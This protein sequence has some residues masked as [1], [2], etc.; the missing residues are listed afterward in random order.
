MKYTSRVN[1]FHGCGDVRT[2]RLVPP[3]DSW[4]PIKGL[5]GNTTPAAALPFG[6]YSCLSYDGAYPS[7]Y[8]VNKPNSGGP[9]GKMYDRKH[10]I[11]LSHFHQSGVG[12]SRVTA[13]RPTSPRVRSSQRR[14]SR[15][16]TP[17]A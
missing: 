4:H 11:G 7:G 3:A 15:A 2:G 14:L 17:R 5:A 16:I 8:G 1:P 9:I 10:F 13:T 6:K 12:D